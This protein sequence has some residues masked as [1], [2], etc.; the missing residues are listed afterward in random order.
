MALSNDLKPDH[1]TIARFINRLSTHIEELFESILLYCDS[2]TL[3]YLSDNWWLQD[4][5][6]CDKRL[7]RNIR[8][9]GDVNP[10]RERRRLYDLEAA[11][12]F[13][14]ILSLEKQVM[15]QTRYRKFCQHY[16]NSSSPVI[17]SLFFLV[18]I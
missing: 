2:L 9:T 13:S 11:I 15:L 17:N 7:Q 5:I 3:W 1:A 4:F 14:R 12:H 18:S 8:W 10:W 6:K 16:E